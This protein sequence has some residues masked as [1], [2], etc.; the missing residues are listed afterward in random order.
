MDNK[1]IILSKIAEIMSR[2]GFLQKSNSEFKSR[3]RCTGLG[4]Y[5]ENMKNI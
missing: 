2:K 5:F 1:E 3:L 4:E